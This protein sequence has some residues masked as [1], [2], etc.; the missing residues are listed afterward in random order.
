M[1]EKF[2]YVRN[3]SNKSLTILTALFNKMFIFPSKDHFFKYFYK[4][5]LARD[6]KI[7]IMHRTQRRTV[8]KFL[9]FQVRRSFLLFNNVSDNL[10]GHLLIDLF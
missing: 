4:K 3:N 6:L 8:V 5:V 2:H 7:P 9:S 1:V 10:C